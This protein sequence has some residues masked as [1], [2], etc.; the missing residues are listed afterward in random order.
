MADTVILK[1]GETLNGTIVSETDQQIVMN[2]TIS[3]GIVDEK[4]IAKGDVQ[5]V[6]KTTPD[7]IAYAGIREYKPETHSLQ[8]TAYPSILKALE[9]FLKTYP[10]SARAAEVKKNLEGLK[11]EQAR[12]KAGELKWD[13]RWYTAQEAEKNKYQLGGLM[14]LSNMRDQAA[15]RDFIGALNTFAQIEKYFP[16]SS[17]YPDAVE[18]AQNMM[19]IAAMDMVAIQ[20]KTKAQETQF[21]NG[22]LLVPEPQKSQMLAARRSQI[23]AAEA[24]MAAAEK[25]D[26]KWKPLLPLA[27]KSFESLKTMLSTEAPRLEKLSVPNMRSSLAATKA[28]EEALQANQREEVEAKLKEAQALWADNA[29]IAALTAELKAKPTPTPKAAPTATPSSS[30]AATPATKEKKNSIFPWGSKS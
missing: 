1:S 9:G 25:G 15:N 24:A 26:L 4:T 12:V 29:Q 17:A 2:V 21:N 14:T 8:P 22:I 30:P 13:D 11:Q 5:S 10:T 16:G 3:S 19:R 23:A 18:L 6:S 27:P 20:N 7:E 28:A